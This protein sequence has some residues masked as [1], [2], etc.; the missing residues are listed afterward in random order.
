MKHRPTNTRA[1]AQKWVV[2]QTLPQTEKSVLGVLARRYSQRWG[3]SEVT[4]QQ[5]ADELGVTRETANRALKRLED[6]GVISVGTLPR[7]KG[8]WDR[9]FYT[10]IEFQRGFRIPY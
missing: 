8:Q 2:A 9:K 10:L 6:K 5:I 7:K 3:R 1:A 4:Q